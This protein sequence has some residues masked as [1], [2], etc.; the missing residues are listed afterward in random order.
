MFVLS[1][2][3]LANPNLELSLIC[4]HKP[5]IAVSIRMNSAKFVL[6]CFLVNGMVGLPCTLLDRFVFESES[7]VIFGQVW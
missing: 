6:C 2:C 7:E 5:S 4:R 3:S 1:V